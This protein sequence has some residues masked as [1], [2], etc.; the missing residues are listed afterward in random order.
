MN[1]EKKYKRRIG[2]AWKKL[3]NLQY[4]DRRSSEDEPKFIDSENGSG[5]ATWR[6]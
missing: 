1:I 4:P 6:G 5:E 3:W 2:Q